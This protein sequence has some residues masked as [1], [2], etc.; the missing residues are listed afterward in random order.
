MFKKNHIV[1]SLFLILI[2]YSC[3]GQLNTNTVCRQKFKEARNL[4]YSTRQSALD[5]A[6]LLSNECL[7][8]DS[9]RKAVV[10]F[11]ITLLIAMKKYSEG[12]SFVD[13]LTKNDFIYN[14]KKGMIYKNF[15]A[16]MYALKNDT[17]KQNLVYKEMSYELEQY[18][19][20]QNIS[21][22]EFEE[23]Y[24]DLFSIKENILDS[25]QINKEVDSLKRRFPDKQDF[26]DFLKK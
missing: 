17:V 24:L 22:K 1:F 16:L 8:C 18:L 2:F 13:S 15:R 26:F 19:Q 21:D 5:S 10:D 3:K 6:L 12:M 25:N 11:K 4:A 9:I 20:K 14:Y 23:A 7:K